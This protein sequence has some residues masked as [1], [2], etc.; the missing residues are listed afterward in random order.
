[1]RS[2]A[3]WAALLDRYQDR[4]LALEHPTLSLTPAQNALAAVGVLPKGARLHVV[5]HSRGGLV[6]DILSL[7]AAQRPDVRAY[8]R[9]RHPDVEV[10]AQLHEELTSR[11]ITVARFARVASPARG[12]T[13]ASRRLDAWASVLLN[14]VKVM[15]V[16]RETG[17]AEL[18]PTR[19][20]HRRRAPLPRHDHHAPGRASPVCKRSASTRATTSGWRTTG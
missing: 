8:G 2:T 7:A 19:R 17:T 6:G 1:V 15:P 14:I 12:T 10:L 11:E 20:C 5:S 16:M 9:T 18:K 3:E 13:L 4:I